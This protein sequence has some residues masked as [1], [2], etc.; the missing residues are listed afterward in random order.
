M[1]PTRG[2]PRIPNDETRREQRRKR[3][4]IAMN[5]ERV[6]ALREEWGMSK[7]EMA[8]EAGVSVKAA[9]RAENGEPVMASTARGVA[10]ALRVDPPQSLGRPV[11]A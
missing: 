3:M 8:A 1:L 9:R 7:R 11:R 5:A 2:P 4:R 6:R 10:R